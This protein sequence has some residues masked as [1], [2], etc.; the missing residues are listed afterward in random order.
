MCSIFGALYTNETTQDFRRQKTSRLL[1][2]ALERGRDGLGVVG[3]EQT[4]LVRE[5]QIREPLPRAM[6][7]SEGAATQLIGNARAEP[8]TEYVL[9]KKQSDQ[10]PYI[11]GKW[12]IVHNGTIANDK[13]LRTYALQ[14]SI[15]SAAIV[16]QLAQVEND[17]EHLRWFLAT[18]RKLRGSYAILAVH[19]DDPEAL[20]YACNYRPIWLQDLNGGGV[21]LASSRWCLD[22]QNAR[23]IEPYT[24]G[25]LN[26]SGRVFSW[27]LRA[28][29]VDRKERV[30]V[31]AS[32]G[33]D[34]TV[35][36]AMLINEGHHVE[37][38]HF[39][40]G[41]RA[42][43]PETVAV[44]AIA[45][46]L[47]VRLHKMD[48]RVYSEADSPLLQSDSKIA[49]GE[50]G[51]EFAHEWVPARN[52]MMLARATA[53]AEANGF[54]YIALGNNLEEAGAYPDNEPE[55]I[56]RFNDLLDFAVGDGKRIRVLQPVGKM[57]KH[58]IVAEGHRVDAPL[59]LTWSCYRAG[60]VH[61]GTCGPCYMRRTAFDINDLP[62]CI[63]YK[64]KP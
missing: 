30:L 27:P 53:Y 22:R 38:C 15:D 18:V 13:E 54:D 61:C 46:E 34:S 37:L 16:E 9:D 49:G 6:Y 24:A 43:G 36:A 26:T 63:E 48:M 23:M 55:F 35:A 42:E 5:V 32:G 33:L 3:R 44:E 62:E 51:A 56:D 20:Y 19:E 57:M 2:T 29:G 47:N 40:Y 60:D 21:L 45:A 64:E 17:S 41:S 25:V 39:L 50:E 14:T 10:Q 4:G 31:V 52:L 8:T 11:L 59:H 1:D 7:A 12:S 28:S 58:E